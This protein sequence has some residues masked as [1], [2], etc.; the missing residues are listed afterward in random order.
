MNVPVILPAGRGGSEAEGSRGAVL[1]FCHGL[2]PATA[3]KLF[4]RPE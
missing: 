2:P 1:G 4:L 3:G